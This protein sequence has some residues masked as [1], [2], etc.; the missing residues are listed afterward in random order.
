MIKSTLTLLRAMPGSGKSTFINYF[1]L[2]S[3]TLSYDS[4]RE[5]YSGLFLDPNTGL[6]CIDQSKNAFIHDTFMQA[7]TYRLNENVDIFIDNLNIDIST[8]NDF[9]KIAEEKNYNFR[10]IN[11]ELKDF[12]FYLERNKNRETTKQLSKESLLNLYTKFQD[13]DLT[14]FNDF[15][16][17]ENEFENDFSSRLLSNNIVDLSNYNNV[18]HF[19]EINGAYDV[20]N[21]ALN[22]I[23]FSCDSNDFYIFTGNYFIGGSYP[24]E[25]L[26][27]FHKIKNYPNVCFLT[28]GDD[29]FKKNI[30]LDNDVFISYNNKNDL[31]QS[32]FLKY[33]NRSNEYI[34]KLL[35][36]ISVTKKFF[37][38]SF[39]NEKYFV[40]HAGVNNVPDNITLINSSVFIN[41]NIKSSN[42][43]ILLINDFIQVFNGLNNYQDEHNIALKN[44]ISYA[45]FLDVFSAFDKKVYSFKNENI[46]NFSF[47]HYLMNKYTIN[48]VTIKEQ[49][50]KETI[51]NKMNSLNKFA[52]INECNLYHAYIE[53]GN[54]IFL[55][56][57]LDVVSLDQNININF[58]DYLND[59][60][61]ILS[62]VLF[63]DGTTTILSCYFK[64][65]ENYDCFKMKIK[66]HNLL[67][68]NKK[69][70][71][72]LSKIKNEKAFIEHFLDKKNVSSIFV[73]D[74]GFVSIINK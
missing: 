6:P 34:N 37:A 17:N 74:K 64:Q 49:T 44:N 54:I 42:N 69:M 60:Y 25:T 65:N 23:N 19:G 35:D 13:V 53:K 50:I 48:N 5:L 63:N 67:D 31:A 56:E 12:D 36:F 7:L 61:S 27:F 22:E 11:F 32:T 15:I 21:D 62:F 52:Y 45:G 8:I 70:H 1:N 57:K 46:N 26:N 39:N 72:N 40:S 3:N 29:S 58:K 59:E 38:Y 2:K 73:I 16:I 24:L 20:L 51:L 30:S 4:F 41:G 18:Y 47:L 10:I 9:K 33:V 28:G 71:F 55:N 43:Q 14:E 68:E 66:K